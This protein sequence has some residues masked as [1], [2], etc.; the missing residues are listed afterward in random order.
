MGRLLN[1]KLRKD[2]NVSEHCYQLVGSL[3]ILFG[4]ILG[5]SFKLTVYTCFFFP[6]LVGAK[7][8]KKVPKF[9]LSFPFP[10]AFALE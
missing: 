4:N 1:Q 3:S 5:C 10:V 8:L 9:W 6:K 7:I 2:V